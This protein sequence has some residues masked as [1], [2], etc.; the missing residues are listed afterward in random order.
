MTTDR[1]RGRNRGGINPIYYLAVALAACSAANSRQ[2]GT[3]FVSGREA[4]AGPE[5]TAACDLAAHRCSRCHPIDRVLLARVNTPQ[6]WVEYVDRMR[7]QP[8]SN[9]AAAEAPTIVRCLV[10]HT[11]GPDGLKTFEQEH[12]QGGAR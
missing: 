11:F 12:A 6:H 5:I 8:E 2:D 3:V 7:H 4:S 9:I 10:F 1:D